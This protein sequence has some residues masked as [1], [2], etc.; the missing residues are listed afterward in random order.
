M[1]V[2]FDALIVMRQFVVHHHPL[3]GA[4]IMRETAVPPGTLYPMLARLVREGWISEAGTIPAPD[5]PASRFYRLTDNGRDAFL[6][7]LARLTIPEKFGPAFSG[8]RAK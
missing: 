2:T 5:R 1:N 6:D 3:C 4:E 8:C 7:R